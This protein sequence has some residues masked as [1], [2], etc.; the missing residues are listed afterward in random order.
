MSHIPPSHDVVVVHEDQAEMVGGGPVT[1]RL[2]ADASATGGALSCA[3]I[4]LAG[5]ASGAALHHH[6]RCSE[7]FY[8][9]SGAAELLAGDRVL[10]ARQGDLLVVPPGTV[11]AFAAAPASDADLVILI[12]PG[13]GDSGTS[14][15]WNG[16]PRARSGPRASWRSRNS[17]TTISTRPRSGS[18][19]RLPGSQGPP[20][21][22][23]G[24]PDPLLQRSRGPR[25]RCLR[26]P[27]QLAGRQRHNAMRC[28]L[29]F[30]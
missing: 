18:G 12:I 11:H 4:M 3:R 10:S 28:S 14:G 1:G 7:L 15:T 24:S 9:V 8:V 30:L 16:S 17:T 20:R 6:D 25:M 2:Y 26:R 5:G 27:R 21:S 23:P 22:R 13:S 29:P 19:S